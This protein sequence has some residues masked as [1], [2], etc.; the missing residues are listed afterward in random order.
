MSY[1]FLYSPLH[2]E[3]TQYSLISFTD[4][5]IH[6]FIQLTIFFEGQLC[7]VLSARFIAMSKFVLL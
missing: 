2:I 6:P 3:N 5:L 4:P 7:A 1:N